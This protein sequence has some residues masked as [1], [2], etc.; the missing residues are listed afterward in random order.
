M[1]RYVSVVTAVVT[2][3]LI[4]NLFYTNFY[5]LLHTVYEKAMFACGNAAQSSVKLTTATH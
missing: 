4:I 3:V 5:F 2:G 1:Q